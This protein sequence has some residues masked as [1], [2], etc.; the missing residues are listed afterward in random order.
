MSEIERRLSAI[1]QHMQ[2]QQIDAWIVTGSDPHGSEYVAPRWRTRAWIS[3]FTGSAGTVVITAERA[4]LWVDSRYFIQAEQQIAGTSFELMKI[5]TPQVPDYVQFLVDTLEYDSVVG[6]CH[7]YMTMATARALRAAFAPKQISLV[8]TDD[9]F[10]SVWSDRPEIPCNRVM[11]QPQEIA[12]ASAQEKIEQIRAL[13]VEKKCSHTIISSL[14]DIAWI[15]N[16]RG[17]DIPYN[18]V[19]MA[20]LMISLTDVVLFT[21]SAHFDEKLT[22][23]ITQLCTL[24]Q[25]DEV[26]SSCSAACN[27]IDV[28]YLCPEKTNMRLQSTIP[29]RVTIIEGRDISTELKARKTPTEIEGMRR[30]HLLDG[31]AMVT[32]LAQLDQEPTIFTEISLA[33]RLAELRSMHEEYMGPSF[34]PI[35]GYQEHGALNHYSASEE[36]DRE[37]AGNGLLVLDTG[38][39]YTCGTTDITRT[40]LF[41]EPTEQMQR[42]YTLVLKGNLA[43]AAQRFPRGTCG[44]QLDVL[45]RQYLWQTGLSYGHGT[46]HGVG[47][48]LNVHEGPQNI[49]PKPIIAPLDVGVI[50]SDEPGIYRTGEYGIRLE[51]LVVVQRDASTVF[52]EFYAFE[53]L[54]LCPFE[55]KL[56]VKDMLNES[57][58]TM[59]NAY[60]R[61]VYEELSDRVPESVATYL[62]EATLPL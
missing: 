34:A 58:L 28:L 47:F 20:Y 45:A 52:G 32:L 60:H 10:T 3:G 40:L 6:T 12:G 25:Y 36:S 49:S 43:L 9:W 16:V 19:F 11:I 26:F 62:K 61:W 41:G 59:L 18:P 24:C 17:D 2:Q 30:A 4:L 50:L 13:L 44:Y 48:C 27:H 54:T 7:L 15:L 31:I 22:E 57:E 51:N 14:D 8:F 33:Q 35:A 46:G 55:R 1:R 5:D 21:D 53:V 23:H 37:L 38:G 29:V 42:D 56:I 39:Q